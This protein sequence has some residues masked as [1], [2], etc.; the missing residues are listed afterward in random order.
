MAGRERIDLVK[1]ART[2][3]IASR[4][5]GQLG[6]PGVGGV[7]IMF[8]HDDGTVEIG[9]SSRGEDSSQPYICQDIE[10]TFEAWASRYRRH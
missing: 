8:V 3:I 2:V 9:A 4:L 5:G 7:V 1:G 10:A 6:D